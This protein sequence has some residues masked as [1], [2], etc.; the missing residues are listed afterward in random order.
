MV[1]RYCSGNW[2]YTNNCASFASERFEEV[3]GVDIDADDW[4]GIETPREIGDSILQANGGYPSNLGVIPTAPGN[5]DT[6]SSRR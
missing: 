2:R 5:Q 3:T 1:N 4:L 6:S